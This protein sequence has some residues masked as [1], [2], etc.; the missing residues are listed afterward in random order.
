MTKRTIMIATLALI[1]G[2]GG[3]ALAQQ[4][5][6]KRNYFVKT[7]NVKEVQ[8]MP[9]SDE[10]DPAADAPEKEPLDFV[11]RNFQYVSMCDWTTG[12]RFMCLPTKED[13]VLKRFAEA[14]TGNMISSRR[15]QNQVLIYDSHSNTSGNLHEHVNFHLEDNPNEVYYFEVP[16]A[17]FD[18]YCYSKTGV[19][20][21]AYLGDVDM[22]MDSLVGKQV[23]LLERFYCQDND[24]AGGG[25]SIV[26]IG[27][28]NRGMVATITKVGVGT[29]NFPVKIIV[30]E[31]DSNGK[32]GREFFQYVTISRTNC[33]LRDED[34]GRSDYK[35]HT[36][37][38]SFLLLAD[39]MAVSPEL[40]AWKGKNVYTFFDTKMRDDKE[41][42]VN[43]DRLTPFVVEDLF[44]LSDSNLLTLMLKSIKTG[45]IYSKEVS[46]TNTK[47][48]GN[49]EVLDELFH[50]GNPS[51]LEGVNAA[52]LPFIKKR[53]VKKGFTEAEV[54]LALGE[55]SDITR[56]TAGTYQWVYQ[57]IDTNRPFRAVKF[58]SKTKKVIQDMTR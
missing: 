17:S 27:E 35:P 32:E 13:L 28:E 43:V 12:M 48:T 49:E 41:K 19:P 56:I 22:A 20:T 25:F 2:M 50:E 38:G 21:L 9:A 39:R 30:K 42:Y 3:S 40:Q 52:N 31:P 16:T 58:N 54:R 23:R 53:Q 36:F 18:D 10:G 15:L 4:P 6:V 24:N 7:S 11:S 45:K 14:K 8:G 26:D 5:V 47:V 29:R 57:Y 1:T 46:V 55:P 37:Q 44:K 51:K 33:G 34:F